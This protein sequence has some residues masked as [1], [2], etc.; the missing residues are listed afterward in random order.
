MRWLITGGCGFIGTNLVEHLL[1]E[2]GHEIRVLDNLSTG[3]REALGRVC[4]F[5]EKDAS[6]LVEPPPAPEGALVEL[7]KGDIL[8]EPLAFSAARGR[9]V[10]VH[11]AASTG[12]EPSLRH[13][14]EDARANVTG[15]LHMLE[16]SRRAGVGRFVFA[17]SGAA[18]GAREPPVHEEVAPHPASPYGAGKLAGEAYCSAYRRAYG[19]GTVVLRFGNV[20]GPR[21]GR[22][23]SVVARFLRQALSGETLHIHGDGDQT[24]DFIYVGDL[25][26]AL[27]LAASAAGVEGET[28][29]I[30]TNAETTVNSLAKTLLAA[31]KRAGIRNVSLERAPALP[32]EV[33]RSCLDASK[34]KRLLGWE[35]ETSLA[36]GVEETLTWFLSQERPFEKPVRP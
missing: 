23:E 34:A 5:A 11:L 35:A 22:K 12:I 13:P 18:V 33:R 10:V 17:S 1:G 2:G 3:T 14:L 25:V 7:V 9:D 4:A 6:G 21:S 32:G 24:R 27:A 28:F 20:Y 36:E 15:T 31:L 19:L 29:Q 26:R 16:A 30:G 8:D